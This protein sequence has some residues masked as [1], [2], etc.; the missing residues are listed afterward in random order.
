LLHRPQ[1]PLPGLGLAFERRRIEP[2]MLLGEIER[3]G[4]RFP[5][6][7]AAVVDRRQAAV[8]I[9]REIVRLARAGRTD[10]ERNVLV[11]ESELLGDPERAKGA[12]AG[13]AVNA[14]VGHRKPQLIL[15][16]PLSLLIPNSQESFESRPLVQI[17][18]AEAPLSFQATVGPTIRAR[19]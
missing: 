7:E 12:G 14:Q 5:Q 3:D 8:G 16:A 18:L 19:I 13:N 6:D 4:E 11:I 9:D 15:T 1:G 2:A 10:F 17:I